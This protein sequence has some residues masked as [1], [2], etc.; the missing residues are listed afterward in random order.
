MGRSAERMSI[1]GRGGRK[2]ERSV[3]AEICLCRRD[4]TE[5]R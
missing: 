5:T 3:E 1:T 4:G 2:I